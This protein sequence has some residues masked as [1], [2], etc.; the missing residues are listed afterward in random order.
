MG[1]GGLT[2]RGEG[3][4]GAEMCVCGSTITAVWCVVRG[5]WSLVPRGS[6][7]GGGRGVLL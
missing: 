5:A 1:G 2:T 6:T 7:V 4:G 3:G